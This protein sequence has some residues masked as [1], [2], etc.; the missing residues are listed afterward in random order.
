M[1][2]ELVTAIADMNE[3]EAMRLS[4]PCSTPARIPG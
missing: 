1:K 2:E 3:D 4:R